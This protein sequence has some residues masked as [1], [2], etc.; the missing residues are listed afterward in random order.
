MSQAVPRKPKEY[1][2]GI[3]IGM[4]P[5]QTLLYCGGNGAGGCSCPKVAHIRKLSPLASQEISAPMCG[6]LRSCKNMLITDIC[7]FSGGSTIVVTDRLCE[8]DIQPHVSVNGS[9]VS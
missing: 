8:T 6:N 9:R 7:C 1:S 2:D 4:D 3:P 5:G